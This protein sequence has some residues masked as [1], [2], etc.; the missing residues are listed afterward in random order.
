MSSWK[1]DDLQK[2]AWH[3]FPFFI[4]I[5]KISGYQFIKNGT[6]KNRPLHFSLLSHLHGFAMVVILMKI[7]MKNS[8]HLFLHGWICLCS[9]PDQWSLILFISRTKSNG[10][11]ASTVWVRRQTAQLFYKW[12]NI[13]RENIT[14]PHYDRCV[15]IRWLPVQL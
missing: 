2:V 13:K 15:L 5:H 11:L 4:F 9:F 14:H 7:L 6:G 3:F 1:N 8:M 10:R 12:S